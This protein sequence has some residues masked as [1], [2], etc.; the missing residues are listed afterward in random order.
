MPAEKYK[1]DKDKKHYVINVVPM[2]A[3][4]MSSSDR[5]KTNP[6]HL[7]PLK[8]Q[9]TA[10][11]RYFKFKDEI[12]SEIAKFGISIEDCVDVVFVM[13][14]PDSW[15]EKKKEKMNGLP[16][17]QRPDIDNMVKG[18]MDAL[19]KEDSHIWSLKCEKRWGYKGAIIIYK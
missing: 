14:M 5:W 9:R 4:R 19:F 10:V 1:I 6:N 13:P 17:S 7:D 12:R 16:H 3:V 8:R 2:G 18:F 11:T 15:S